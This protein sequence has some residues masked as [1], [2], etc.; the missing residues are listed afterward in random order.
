MRA[1]HWAT[2]PGR[3]DGH[4]YDEGDRNWGGVESDGMMRLRLELFVADLNRS[5]AWYVEV[6]GFRQ[7]RA[8]PSY[9]SLQRGSVV[10]GL[11]PTAGLPPDV[12]GSGHTQARVAR[13]PG[14]GVE[15]VLE[16][17]DRAAVEAAAARVA[18]KGWP[19]T[20]ALTDQPW[21]LRDFRMVDPDG[22]YLR[23]THGNAAAE[24]PS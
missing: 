24:S 23:I 4:G 21:G 14:A 13:E 19:L 6:L 22:Y 12:T 9:A 8:D 10:L 1:W 18:E 7:I 15:V 17:E 11:G 16:L 2:R 20:E 5:V 3:G